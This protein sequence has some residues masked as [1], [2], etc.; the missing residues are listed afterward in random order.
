MLRMQRVS[1]CATAPD[2]T[3]PPGRREDAMFR[4]QTLIFGLFDDWRM[5]WTASKVSDF[6]IRIRGI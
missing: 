1:S 5:E 6:M 3:P 2:S 4:A